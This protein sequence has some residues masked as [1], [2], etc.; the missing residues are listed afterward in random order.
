MCHNQSFHG[1]CRKPAFPNTLW[2]S[3]RTTSA[4]NAFKD[5]LDSLGQELSHMNRYLAQL[6]KLFCEWRLWSETLREFSLRLWRYV[7]THFG[8]KGFICVLMYSIIRRGN[9]VQLCVVA[10]KQQMWWS[11]VSGI[12]TSE[13][14]IS[15]FVCCLLFCPMES[16]TLA[17]EPHA[18]CRVGPRPKLQ[19]QCVVE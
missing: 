19:S 2:C 9:V 1:G 14:D 7:K 17:R 15:T 11:V 18:S 3:A 13:L 4:I 16:Q 5:V 12:H 10:L 8:N 6:L